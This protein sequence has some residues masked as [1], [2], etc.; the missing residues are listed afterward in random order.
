M[1]AAE[2]KFDYFTSTLSI[3]PLKNADIIN[4]IGQSLQDKYSVKFLIADF[5]KNNGF[6]IP[7][8]YQKI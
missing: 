6:K 1:Y 7:L 5:K 2:N 8:I 3:S 4:E